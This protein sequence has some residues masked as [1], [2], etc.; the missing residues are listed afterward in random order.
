MTA[1]N[2]AP[3][4][5]PPYFL[6]RPPLAPDAE[7]A[8]AFDALFD[9]ACRAGGE[10]DYTLPWPRWQFICH[11]ADTREVILHGSQNLEITTFEPRKSS[12][13]HPFGDRKAVFGASDGLW[14]I[15]YAIL[16]R[17]THP[18]SLCNAAF[19]L[20]RADG[21]LGTPHYFFSISRKALAARPY[22]PGAVYFL[23]RATFEP[24]PPVTSDGR[25]I[26]VAQ[27]A[28]LQP[29]EPLTRIKVGPEDF[30]F[31]AEIR[32]HDDDTLWARAKADPDGFPWFDEMAGDAP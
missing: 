5:L 25:V 30:P 19:R 8:A 13:A 16:D 17:A 32:G 28:S 3:A 6:P 12:D 4:P 10:I 29:T 7:A 9:S 15:Y 20:G 14:P 2:A 22:A 26:H 27:W 31:L 1:A 11:I 24:M 21:S 18:M 23:P